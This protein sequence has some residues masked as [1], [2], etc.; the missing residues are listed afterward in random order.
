MFKTISYN[1]IIKKG[2]EQFHGNA[3]AAKELSK[4]PES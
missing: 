2:G 1:S 3:A 4:N